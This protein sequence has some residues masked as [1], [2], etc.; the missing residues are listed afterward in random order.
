MPE[1]ITNNVSIERIENLS[2]VSLKVSSK[3]PDDARGKLQLAL[4]LGASG[5]DPQSLWLGPDRWLLISDSMSA[6]DIIS[7]CNRT[8]GEIIHNAVDS[9]AA[10]ESLRIAGSDAGRLLATGSGI[11]FRPDKFRIG[12][13]CR[14]RLAQVATVIVATAEEQFEIYVDH[15]YGHYLADWLADTSNIDIPNL[16]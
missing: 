11:D 5:S 6:D 14:T 2:I 10:L 8:L 9:S 1:Q 15:S 16:G 12:S 13:C 7:N 4:P 3:S